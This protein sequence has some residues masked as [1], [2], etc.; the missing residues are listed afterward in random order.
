MQ[1]VLITAIGSAAAGAAIDSLHAQ[2]LRVAGCDIYPQSWTINA[3]LVDVF[4]RVPTTED[5]QAYIGALCAFIK[6]ES[7][8]LVIPLTDLE[9]DVLCACKDE[10]AALGA[11]VCTP[12]E[13]VVRLCRDKLKMAEA[14]NQAGI[15]RTIPTLPAQAV[16]ASAASYPMMLKPVSGRSSRGQIVVHNDSE[17]KSACGRCSGLIAQP[18]LPGPVWTVD[19]VRGQDGQIAAIAREELL[20][21]TNGL[22]ITVQVHAGHPLCEIAKKIASF[23]DILGAV[24][25]EFICH[26]NEYWFLEVNP[27]FSGGVGFSK[28]AGYDVVKNQLR[29]HM[30]LLIEADTAVRSCTLSQ[31]YEMRLTAE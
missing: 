21:T 18:Y 27:R 22:G 8:S 4:E 10:L 23:A 24:N 31:R 14:L 28:L 12:E 5:A 2:G 29:A 19:V 9:V 13:S 15:C 26:Q 16:N 11:Q 17:L 1:T 30:G 25:M 3:Q 20:R 7:I 6:R